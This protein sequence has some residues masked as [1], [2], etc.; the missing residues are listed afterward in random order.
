MRRLINRI[1]RRH[2]VDRMREHLEFF[3]V[4]TSQ[5][6]RKQLYRRLLKGIRRIGKVVSMMGV[7]CEE[8][9]QGLHQLSQALNQFEQ[10]QE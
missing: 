5:M 6:S 1:R 10:E 9:A 4:D 8:A 7:T 2:M 3:G